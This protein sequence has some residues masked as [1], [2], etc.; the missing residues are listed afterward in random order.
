SGVSAHEACHIGDEPRADV[1]GANN[2]GIDAILID[3][4]GKYEKEDFTIV[5]SFLELL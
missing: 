1:Q 5:R 4:K 3:R 2:S